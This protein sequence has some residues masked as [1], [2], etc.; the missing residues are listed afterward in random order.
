MMD[1]DLEDIPSG[2]GMGLNS[3]SLP[4]VEIYNYYYC[5]QSNQQQQNHKNG[6]N[7]LKPNV[8]PNF[9]RRRLSEKHNQ[10]IGAELARNR[11]FYKT[12]DVRPPYTYASLI[13]QGILESKDQQLTLNE[14]YTWFQDTFAFF[15]RNAAT[16][17]VRFIGLLNIKN[18]N[19]QFMT[20]VTVIQLHEV[21]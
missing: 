17:K 5:M 18:S 8:S 12:H 14:I 20:N 6:R 13:R 2:S 4:F 7:H 16:W 19:V 10:P 21:G 1:Q 9:S 3:N 11:D 15:R